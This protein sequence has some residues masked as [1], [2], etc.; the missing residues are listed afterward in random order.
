MCAL[1]GVVPGSVAPFRWNGLRYMLIL[2]AICLHL[3]EKIRISTCHH[4]MCR[5][6]GVLSG[7]VALL[8]WNGNERVK[9]LH[10]M[11]VGIRGANNNYGYE[12][13]VNPFRL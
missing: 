5:L 1:R 8:R 11:C 7:S 6:R 10:L 4:T 3:N 2:Y 12:L 13:N 9:Y